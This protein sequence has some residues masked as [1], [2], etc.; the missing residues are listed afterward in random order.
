M[1]NLEYPQNLEWKGFQFSI[2]KV[3]L[4]YVTIVRHF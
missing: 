4:E 3:T 1:M 2:V